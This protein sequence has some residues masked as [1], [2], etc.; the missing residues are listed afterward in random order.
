MEQRYTLRANVRLG[1]LVANQALRE[2]LDAGSAIADALE[3]LNTAQRRR[4]DI[5]HR[6]VL[7]GVRRFH[8]NNA[9]WSWI[10]QIIH[11]HLTFQNTPHRR[12]RQVQVVK[13]LTVNRRL[14]ALQ[15]FD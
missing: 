13:V 6:Q 7:N 15:V 9:A 2:F 10:E 11:R 12:V 3:I 4:T 1:Q 14:D 8:A 5:R